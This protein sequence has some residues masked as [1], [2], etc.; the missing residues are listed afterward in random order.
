MEKEE[1]DLLRIESEI[2][3][4]NAER[5]KFLCEANQIKELSHQIFSTRAMLQA[6]LGGIVAAGLL[7]VWAIDYLTPILQKKR[8]LA[9]LENKILSEMNKKQLLLIDQERISNE[10]FKKSLENKLSRALALNK[11]LE[12]DLE[13]LQKTSPEIE[14][15]GKALSTTKARSASLEHVL[16][17]SKLEG[18]KWAYTQLGVG[19]G[20]YMKFQPGG[21]FLHDWWPSS[22]SHW[23]IVGSK[24][25]IKFPDA[26]MEGTIE[27]SNKILGTGETIDGQ[28]WDWYAEKFVGDID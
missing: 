25:I 21:E 8:E 27:S 22:E 2:N 10:A 13:F 19:S 1:S 24:I 11:Q 9:S 3:K 12:T 23:T 6:V 18:T 16:T 26:Q 5:D 7:S 28:V 14:R 20:G 15:F 4:N 17:I